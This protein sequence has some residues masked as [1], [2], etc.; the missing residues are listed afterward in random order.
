MIIINDKYI[1]VYISIPQNAVF[2]EPTDEMVVVKDIEMFRYELIFHLN[3]LKRPTK[4]VFKL[5][6]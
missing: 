1:N 4:K 6:A 2:N 3:N 5:I